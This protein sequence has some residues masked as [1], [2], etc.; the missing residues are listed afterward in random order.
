MDTDPIS[1][2]SFTVLYEASEPTIDIV[3]V[4]GFTGH[5]RGTWTLKNSK[6]QRQSNRGDE[7]NLPERRSKIPR[8]L[9]KFGRANSTPSSSRTDPA[10]Q[11]NRASTTES[12][13]AGGHTNTAASAQASDVFWP[14]DLLK[15]TV[16]TARI[17]TYGYDTRIRHWSQGQVSH[18][19]VVDHAADLLSELESLRR[20]PTEVHRPILFIVHSLG[21]IVIKEALRQ[22][23]G[24]TLQPHLRRIYEMAIGAIFFGTPHGGSDPRNAFHH[25][26]TTLAQGAGF[27]P[28]PQIVDTL[29]PT[30]QLLS[31]LRNEFPAMC[32]E[33]EWRVHSFQEQYGLAALFGT[34]VV[35]DASSCLQ[36]PIVE[37]KEHIASN[38][39]DMCRF[40]GLDDPSYRKV[41]AAINR[42]IS[43]ASQSSQSCQISHQPQLP[44]NSKQSS[45]H[46]QNMEHNQ[47]D[48]A[49]AE[50]SGDQHSPT[51]PPGGAT[52]L[53][54]S[55]GS[56][57]ESLRGELIQK[58]YFDR[59][60]ERLTGLSAA[61][62]KT[63]RWFLAKPEY[64]SWLG[65]EHLVEHGGFL[66][67]KGNPGTGKS[68]LMKFLFEKAKRDASDDPSHIHLSFFF[69]A[70]G[71]ADE[72]STTGLYRSL[73]HQLFE[74]TPDLAGS[75][76]WMTLDGARG[77]QRSGWHEEALKQTLK[78]ATE[79]LGNRSLT[80]FVD[81]LDEC[82][83]TQAMGMVEAFE[84]LC[85]LAQSW[86]VS[87]RI[88]FSSRHYP[89]ITIQTGL[90]LVLEHEA[91]H[92][93]DIRTYI[94]SKLR[95]GKT[96]QAE[97]LRAEIL[98]K[99]SGI[100][101]WIVLVIEILN[102]EFPQGS[103]TQF[104]ARL[105]EIPPKLHELFE[106]ILKRDGDNLERLRICFNLILFARRPFLPQELYF[107]IQLGLDP[108]ANTCWDKDD[109]SLYQMRNYVSSSS[110]GLAQVTGNR[111]SEVQFIH[112]SVRD[113]L[114]GRH[115]RQ[116][117]QLPENADGSGH[118]MLSDCCLAQLQ[119]T[120]P[121]Y[122]P[123]RSRQE[124]HVT[125]KYPFLRYSVQY[126]LQH[127]DE[128]QRLGIDQ[129][130]FVSHFPLAAWATFHNDFEDF[131]T[132]KYTK[133][134][135]MLYILAE[136][137]AVHL[138]KAHPDYAQLCLRVENERYET[139]IIAALA[140]GSVNAARVMYSFIREYA[141]RQ[142]V[143]LHPLQTHILEICQDFEK[144]DESPPL[145]PRTF[146]FGRRKDNLKSLRKIVAA[147]NWVLLAHYLL[148][149]N[150]HHFR[151]QDELQAALFLAAQVGNLG[152]ATSV[153]SDDGDYRSN[154]RDTF[155]SK[156]TER[157]RVNTIDPLAREA[158][159]VN[160]AD[161]AGYTPLWKAVKHRHKAMALLLLE[162]GA[163]I[164][165]LSPDGMT[166]IWL[167]LT[168]N[169]NT[170]VR[171]LLEKGSDMEGT[172]RSLT[173]LGW[174]AMEGNI[175]TVRI[176]L[177]MGADKESRSRNRRQTPLSLA[178]EAGHEAV[179]Q[180]LLEKGAAIETR[181]YDGQTPL[182]LAAEAGHKAVV[183][184]L[185][186][187]GADI[188]TRDDE[189]RTPLSWVAK[190]GIHGVQSIPLLIMK[191][192]EIEARDNSGRTALS[193]AAT[194]RFASGMVEV[195]LAN[196]AKPASRDNKGQSPLDWGKKS[197]TSKVVNMLEE[198]LGISVRPHD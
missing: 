177:D 106:M 23:K 70:R 155:R 123:K 81:A 56:I 198:A 147:D 129:S 6:R 121:D 94:K 98:E 110:K 139:P 1:E 28:N 124:N 11:P 143:L 174:A 175:A 115:G 27:R 4:H 49:M 43:I 32:H 3:F 18:N 107:A 131:D 79:M 136:K 162:K 160:V 82:D 80:I 197:G 7:P 140:S 145:L 157:S 14:A 166:P 164:H 112:E 125:A 30:S 167:A 168:Q 182:S 52:N 132:R 97:T 72:K 118:D 29:M 76:D 154:P 24:W 44:Y 141:S 53:Q 51:T 41:V 55:K 83:Q 61:H 64:M 86:G 150:I 103:T 50:E 180:Q 186:E 92:E 170:M 20:D 190:D 36:D 19:T 34:K 58:L 146:T 65:S 22:S 173:P 75:L 90:E 16:P 104:R 2:T 116:W 108:A 184:H 117:S 38:H 105:K 8:V 148:P 144:I 165:C 33:R 15:T 191:G 5:P 111:T 71:D 135:S 88:C 85:E 47:S 31:S 152:L 42:I 66:W 87:L 46:Q 130:S 189:G 193:W 48:Q 179:V 21:G 196:G 142:P 84:E 67:I 89:T 73:L 57:D 69:N 62:G 176:L 169:D 183:Q 45:I 194:N 127:S 96:K 99:S 138:I 187:K 134:V 63:C 195:L 35:D 12:G 10:L 60:D 178:A 120:I 192:A 54:S 171:L 151:E 102:L 163:T 149:P 188:E 109:I 39:M 128:A 185:L 13:G 122:V 114:L 59:I 156:V 40:Y 113:F 159:D 68:T 26:L 74:H 37:T 158:V 137:D 9:S 78:H 95:L 126:V 119:T 100:F 172:Y 17:L 101:L 181:N 25:I 77:I 153:L 133:S 93:E 161:S 91:G